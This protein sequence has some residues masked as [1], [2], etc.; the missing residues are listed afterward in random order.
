MKGVDETKE[1]GKGEK[2]PR[3]RQR[4]EAHEGS[5]ERG[6]N[7]KEG[8]SLVETGKCRLISSYM[9]RFFFLYKPEIFFLDMQ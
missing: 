4:D 9:N 8:R 1:G 7:E 2:K 5:E 6:G 3:G